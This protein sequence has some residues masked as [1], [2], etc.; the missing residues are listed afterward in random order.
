MRGIAQALSC[1]NRHDSQAGAVPVKSA[2]AIRLIKQ[3]GVGTCDPDGTRRP[4]A[5]EGECQRQRASGRAGTR[6]MTVCLVAAIGRRRNGSK[7]KSRPYGELCLEDIRGEWIVRMDRFHL[8]AIGIVESPARESARGPFDLKGPQLAPALHNQIHF[9]L[10][11][12]TP[13]E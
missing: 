7:P 10:R 1:C 8:H 6:T 9:R 4:V 12:C 13:E 2:P 3:G 11:P 5:A